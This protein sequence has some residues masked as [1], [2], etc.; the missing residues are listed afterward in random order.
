[1][2]WYGNFRFELY[3]D[4]IQARDALGIQRVEVQVQ[5]LPNMRIGSQTSAKTRGSQVRQLGDL[6]VTEV[7]NS[8]L[9][10]ILVHQRGQLGGPFT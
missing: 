1:M 10:G 9:I 8:Q 6:V 5:P 4:H 7:D 2:Y 3:P